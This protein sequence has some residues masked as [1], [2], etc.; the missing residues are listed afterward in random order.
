[1]GVFNRIVLVTALIV[2]SLVVLGA[3]ASSAYAVCD[4]WNGS[5]SNDWTD[6]SNW[7]GGEPSSTTDVC[8]S[9]SS[10]SVNIIGAAVSA[11]S[12]TLTNATV[13]IESTNNGT[14][15][16]PASLTLSSGGSVDSQSAIDLTSVC[17]PDCP[18]GGSATLE[19]MGVAPLVNSGL[20]TTEV[21]VD[22]GSPTREIDG[23]ITNSHIIDIKTPTSYDSTLSGGTLDNQGLLSLDNGSVLTVAANQSSIVSDDINGDI[24][25]NSATGYLLVQDGDTYEQGTGAISPATPSPASPAVVVKG[26]TTPAFLTYA[27]N[28]A[29]AIDA[30]QHVTLG[31]SPGINQNLVVD[32]ADPLGGCPGPT[33]VTSAAGFSNA[34]TITMTG[35]CS[36]GVTIASGGLTNTGTIDAEAG[37]ARFINASQPLTQTAGMTILASGTTLAL[38]GN[39]T[40]LA[41]Q[42]GLLEGPG[43][44][45]ASVDNTGGD[46]APGSPTAPG[47]MS[48][49]GSYTQA[50]GGTLTSVIDGTTAGSGYSQL[51]VGSGST[52][53]GTLIIS[54][55]PGFNPTPGDTY[56]ILGG[57]AVTG[58]FTTVTGQ[59]LAEGSF[60]PGWTVGY[61][62]TY[63]SSDVTL[64]AESASGLRVALIG[65]G[66]GSVTSSPSGIDCS[67]ADSP[68]DAPYVANQTVTLTATPDSGWAFGGWGGACSG[69]ATTCEVS[70]SQARSV[71][72]DFANPTTLAF[73]PSF[74]P[75][76]TGTP[77][78]Y[79][80]VV[81]PTP[82][83]GT[84]AFTDGGTA[85]SGCEAVPVST[86]NGD[87]TCTVTYDAVGTHQV[88]A[89]YSGDANFAGSRSS[90]VTE[91][92]IAAGSG[93][94]GGGGTTV[95][96][97]PIV[98]SG[99]IKVTIKCG[100]RSTPCVVIE[101]LTT[102]QG[103]R[104]V[105]IAR[106]VIKIK[107]GNVK[108]IRLTLN[109]TGRRL[110]H[111]LG[112]LHVLLTVKTRSGQV[113]L[114]RKLTLRA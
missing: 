38:S 50:S 8:I 101:T 49:D 31:G 59:F 48:I 20:I 17:S 43:I 53:A 109:A 2:G 113:V 82:D 60:P 16:Q 90:Q 77:V 7:S 108:T 111:Q 52:I 29:G 74:N 68:C 26:T 80:A 11:K 70:M 94:S 14:V 5:V 83:G 23:N 72:A 44:L 4:T 56:T 85:I 9:N 84:V 1:L 57:S 36:S 24:T 54:T 42:G 79:T 27:G 105:V 87:A 15:N 114:T 65:A 95:T 30:R 66:Y 55:P 35:S 106:R 63:N 100:A 41:L 12:L 71:T 112:R 22:T 69:T 18:A 3:G 93:S 34:G 89:T 103:G 78:T 104:T 61:T 6:G 58:T 73:G 51:G 110:L 25:N 62:P 91:S 39:A 10:G 64:D 102:K 33:T 76:T 21:N 97:K 13:G 99:A 32:G 45:N 92:I 46:V 47:H 37:A 86:S 19:N 98:V 40:T 107:H 28:G 81:A 88:M 96:R 75:Q 67:D